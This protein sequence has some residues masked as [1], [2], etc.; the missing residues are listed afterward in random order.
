VSL[1]SYRDNRRT[2]WTY[3]ADGR[4]LSGSNDFTYDAAGQIT[5]FGFADPEITDQQFDGDR[6]RAKLRSRSTILLQVD[7]LTRR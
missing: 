4:L 6:R 3:D 7:C 2:G 5:S 1:E